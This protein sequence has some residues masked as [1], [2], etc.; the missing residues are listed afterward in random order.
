MDS[1]NNGSI[2]LGEFI[3]RL[4]GDDDEVDEEEVKRIKGIEDKK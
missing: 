3:E 4:G 1:D 2:N